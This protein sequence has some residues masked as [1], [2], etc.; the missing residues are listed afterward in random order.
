MFDP[1]FIQSLGRGQCQKP[2]MLFAGNGGGHCP[3]L[4]YADRLRIG[5]IQRFI[6]MFDPCLP[7]R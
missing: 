3:P 4:S 7:N 1:V 6:V 5:R 2:M